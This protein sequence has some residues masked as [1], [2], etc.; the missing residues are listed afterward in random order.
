[1]TFREPRSTSRRPAWEP[2]FRLN[3]RTADGPYNAAVDV[4]YLDNNATTMPDPAV[5]ERVREAC[6]TWWANPSSV[7][8]FGQSVRQKVELAREQVARLIGCRD[9]ELVFTS[10]GTE[11]NNLALDGLLGRTDQDVLITTAVEHSAIREPA[12][13]LVERGVELVHLP[14]DRHG[15]VD[16][17]AAEACLKKYAPGEARATMLLSVQWVNNE[18]G[19][20]QPIE[21][22]AALRS[23]LRE[24]GLRLRFHCDATQAAGKLAID[25]AASGLDLMTL[26]AHKFHGPKGVG[27]LAIRTGVRPKRQIL[28]GPQER[29][30]RGGTENVPGVLGMGLAA[31]LAR[32]WL[33]NPENAGRPQR[34]RD[35][36][37][38]RV[39][40]A[41][42]D[43]MVNGACA[44]RVWNTSNIAFPSL[45]AEAILLGLSERGVCASAGAA[46]SSGSLEPSPVLLAMGLAEAVAHGSVR[47]SL[48]RFTTQDEIDRAVDAVSATVE[49]LRRTMPVAET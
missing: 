9:R 41:V 42:P 27:A 17:E 10:G 2:C 37:E 11:S 28:G 14:I 32:T 5:S 43:A 25:F 1:M 19:V 24:Q 26:S 20:I 18:T 33:E 40:Q 6:E 21:Q 39:G 44:A 31:E 36:F 46:C 45:E 23:R 3:R 47:F 49:K 12:Q 34:L 29:D 48:S 16:V 38:T 35:R 8:R 15:R 13:R 7:H 30:R 4:I 22:L